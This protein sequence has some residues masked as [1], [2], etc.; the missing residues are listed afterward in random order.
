VASVD[1]PNPG[2]VYIDTRATTTPDPGGF[3]LLD[4]EYAITA[5]D[6]T[7]VGDPLQFV[8][9]IDASALSAAG[10]TP[11]NV[12]MFRNGSQVHSPCPPVSARLDD[13]WWPCEES[14]QV[15]TD[16]DLWVT[17]LTM[18]GSTWNAGVSTAPPD[19][20]SDGVPDASDNCVNVANPGQDDADRDGVGAACDTKEV[21]T[22]KDDCKNNG[23]KAFNGIYTFKS[24]GDCVSNVATGGKNKA[25]GRRKH[26]HRHR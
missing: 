25:S 2:P 5:P 24:Q 26:H 6:A 1:S 20:D 4:F 18:A 3:N 12:R 16:G 7:D 15:Q 11:A 13:S 9:K 8:F 22:S 17:V 19:A 21:P 14:R 23:W 10:V